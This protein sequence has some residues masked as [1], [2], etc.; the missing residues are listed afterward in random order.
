MFRSL[1]RWIGEFLAFL[2]AMIELVLLATLLPGDSFDAP[3]AGV[4]VSVI[5]VA[6][7]TV[8]TAGPLLM[9][10]RSRADA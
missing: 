7:A 8:L 2:G 4:L 1:A 3:V 10:G 6:G 9:Y 5:L